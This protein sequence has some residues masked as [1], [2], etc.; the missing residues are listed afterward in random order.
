M[1]KQIIFK[2]IAVIISVY[3]NS[4]QATSISVDTNPVGPTSWDVNIL[5]DNVTDFAGFQFELEFNP[6]V[7]AASGIDSGTIFGAD[8]VPVNSSFN[9]NPI[10]FAET[11]LGS[12]LDIPGSSILATI[13][14]Q[15]IGSGTSV[16]NLKNSLLINSTGDPIASVT[17]NDGQITFQATAPEP[18]LVLLVGV[19]LLSL[20]SVKSKTKIF[21]VTA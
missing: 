20:I 11:T 14:F 7:L 2:L 10:S 6:L 21:P 4:A 13:H 19:G 12:G 5:I 16:L 8:T 17:E 18:S 3:I 9:A 15:A 1:N